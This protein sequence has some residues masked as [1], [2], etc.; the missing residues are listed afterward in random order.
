MVIVKCVLLVMAKPVVLTFATVLNALKLSEERPPWSQPDGPAP[1]NP[2][3]CWPLVVLCCVGLV[4]A[5]A[6]LSPYPTAPAPSPTSSITSRT[7]R[8]EM[9]LRV[10]G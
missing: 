5:K 2:V 1:F 6:L 7:E 3:H 10:A 4:V 8:V 9:P